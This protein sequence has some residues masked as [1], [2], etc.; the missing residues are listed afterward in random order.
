MAGFNGVPE[1][2]QR[3]SLV[4]LV[5]KLTEIIV[6]QHVL[7]ARLLIE[8]GN[9]GLLQTVTFFPFD[10]AGITA[11]KAGKEWFQI[12]CREPG[13]QQELLFLFF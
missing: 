8:Q 10:I 5:R 6:L 4:I 12:I 11:V 9:F 3:F 1:K 13:V 7:Y 2:S